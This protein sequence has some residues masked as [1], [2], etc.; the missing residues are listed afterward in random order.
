MVLIDSDV[1][2]AC[3]AGKKTHVR[4]VTDLLELKAASTTTFQLA[5]IYAKTKHEDLASVKA[6]LDLFSNLEITA[7]AAEMA[8]EF[9]QQYSPY[10]PT[11]TVAD[12]L[13]AATAVISG[14]E[15]YTLHPKNFPMTQVSLYHRTIRSITA[16]SK[17]RLDL[18]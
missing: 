9:W 4:E 3:L 10:Y 2:S 7:S 11:L 6:F 18:G 12:C 15:I 5:E 1:I 14:A 13:V 8:G 16:K 17:L